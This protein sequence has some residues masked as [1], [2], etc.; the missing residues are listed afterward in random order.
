[1][2]KQP[3]ES[4]RDYPP[5][6]IIGIGCRFPGG[7]TNPTQFWNL[8]VDGVDAI[9]EI[10][11][12]RW[13]SSRFYDSENKPGRSYARHGGFIGDVDRFDAAF[14]G[15][16]PREASNTDPQH[17]LLLEVAWEAF[18]DAGKAPAEAPKKTGVFIGISSHD[19]SDIG[20]AISERDAINAYSALGASPS[21][22]ANRLS[23]FFD[24]TGPSLAVDTACS[25]SL[26]AIHLACKSIWDDESSTAL[27][28][29][30]N[31]L[32]RPEGM[33]GFCKASMLSPDGRCKAFDA[34]AN[35]FVRAEG[36][37]LVLLKPYAQAVA[38]GDQIY[39]VILG[40]ATNQDG[41]S[42]GITVPTVSSQT[43]LLREAYAQAKIDPSAVDYMEA[44][45]TGTAVGDPVEAEALGRVLSLGRPAGQTCLIGSVKTN[46]GHLEPA[47]GVAGLI[48]ATLAVKHGQIPPNLHFNSPNPEIP[49]EDLQIRVPRHLE[50]WPSSGSR[51]IAGV[52]SFGFGGSNAHVVL[53]SAP[54][55]DRSDAISDDANSPTVES[56]LAM[57]LPLSAK[58]PETLKQLASAYQRHLTE[59][60]TDALSDICFSAGVHRPHHKHRL[61]AVGAS[62]EEVANVLEAFVRLEGDHGAIAESTQLA[63][64]RSY[65]DPPKLAFIF[66][67]M[68]PQWWAMGRELLTQS[69][70]YR[71]AIT[72]CDSAWRRLADWSLLAELQADA[73]TSRI[74]QTEIAQP[75]IF[76]LQ[77]AL[78][79][80]WRSW[81]VQPDFVLGHSVGEVAAAYVSG[82]LGLEDAFQVVAHRSRLQ[83]TTVGQ[84]TMLAVGLSVDA[85][86]AAIANYEDLVSIAA[87]NGP[88]SVHASGRRQGS[89][90]PCGRIN[91]RRRVRANAR[92]RGSVSQPGDGRHST[93]P[94]CGAG[95]DR[96][97]GGQDNTDF[98]GYW[99]L[100]GRPRA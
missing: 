13:N 59:G 62:K 98:V 18:E 72:E 93:R 8:V 91:G 2:T 11:A 92:S 58:C 64:G 39:A 80:V 1:M 53:A 99:E 63:L 79:A 68:G 51:R 14:F 25:S 40:A 70:V 31:L 56:P 77:I 95:R 43:A 26:V 57:A 88:S 61:A 100:C 22:A 48:K 38:D 49:F 24:F 55:I 4:P 71:E 10:P 74:H 83:G 16:S 12:N 65:P 85:T 46:I 36:A 78:A 87:I 15:L 73:T 86:R 30:V 96:P 21:V 20:S 89:G 34:S 29:G 52:N 50:P 42:A 84:G 44:H 94:H 35:G 69:T 37:G 54:P 41:R 32:L 45:G 66:T 6:A 5:I 82:A 76:S 75:A 9:S 17:R 27:A 28:G 23:Y 7:V 19:F 81:G 47:S 67:G 90:F 97:S 33:I 60:P 3:I